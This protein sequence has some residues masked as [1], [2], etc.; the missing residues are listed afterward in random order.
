MKLIYSCLLLLPVA[1]G[2][3]RA[4]GVDADTAYKNN[5]ARCHT[6]VQQ[7]SQRM[8]KTLLMHMRVRANLPADEV[9]AVL[10]YLNGQPD[11]AGSPGKERKTGATKT[12]K[13]DTQKK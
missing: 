5:C 13:T 3:S 7:Y 10:E 11:S 8:T 1:F 6:S 12:I 4:Q 9:Q 2:P